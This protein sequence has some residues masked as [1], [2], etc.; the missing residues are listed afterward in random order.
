MFRADFNYN[1]GRIRRSVYVEKCQGM[2]LI[3]VWYWTILMFFIGFWRYKGLKSR[4][5]RREERIK[6]ERN[7]DRE[8]SSCSS[9]SVHL[10]ATIWTK[11]TRRFGCVPAASMQAWGGGPE[12]GKNLN[13][14]CSLQLIVILPLTF[15]PNSSSLIFTE[16]RRPR[17]ISVRFLAYTA[18]PALSRSILRVPSLSIDHRRQLAV[19]FNLGSPPSSKVRS[20]EKKGFPWCGV[21]LGGIWARLRCAESGGE[22]GW[23]IRV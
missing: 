7:R 16:I 18:P 17:S 6:T 15:S 9:G 12:G 1:Y 3:Q 20:P 8:P 14:Y 11:A 23:P 2:Y 10:A 13:K 5:Q 4:V 22:F 21:G 19:V